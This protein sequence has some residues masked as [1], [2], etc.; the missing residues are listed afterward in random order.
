MAF[1]KDTKMLRLSAVRARDVSKRLAA[2]PGFEP[3]AL[4][5]EPCALCGSSPQS[6]IVCTE[7]YPLCDECMPAFE[8]GMFMRGH[9]A[10][11][12]CDEECERSEDAGVVCRHGVEEDHTCLRECA[13][14]M[15]SEPCLLSAGCAA[16]V[17][18]RQR[19]DVFRAGGVC[20]CW[21]C[22]DWRLGQGR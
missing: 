5:S 18:R 12:E 22:R 19:V 17:R 10:W 3:V 20:Q 16:G 21:A 15:L 11:D 6:P 1:L 9:A 4:V 7:V 14:V 8:A 13:E 2:L